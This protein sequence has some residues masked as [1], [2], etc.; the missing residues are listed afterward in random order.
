MDFL[1]RMT[2]ALG[3]AILVGWL[4]A[5]THRDARY[6]GAVGAVVGEAFTQLSSAVGLG[7]ALVLLLLAIPVGLVGGALSQAVRITLDWPRWPHEPGYEEENCAV[8]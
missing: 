7:R 2:V 6:L 4:V 8:S 1:S 3:L 5:R